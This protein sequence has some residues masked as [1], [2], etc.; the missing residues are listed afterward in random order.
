[1]STG[2]VEP[3]ADDP[4]TRQTDEGWRRRLNA[5]LVGGIVIMLVLIVGSFVI[6]AVSAYDVRTTNPLDASLPPSADHLFGT[7]STGMDIFTRAFYAPRVD[8]TIAAL[9][10]LLALIG[11]VS[12]GLVAGMSRGLVGE[13]AMRIADTLQAFPTLIVAL[14]IVALAGNKVQ[15]IVW[16]IALLGAP[17]FLRLVRSRVLTV[18]EMRYIEAARAMGKPTWKILIRDILPNSI[19]PVIVQFGVLM[20]H[21]ILILAGLAFL[22]VGV[23]A[24]TPEWGTMILAGR[25]DI[26]TGEWWTAVFPGLML[27]VAV[28]GFHLISEGLERARE[29][30]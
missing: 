8:L 9:G 5:P 1:M 22:G 21:G 19:S 23:Q 28:V 3:I 4:I 26:T 30:S 14:A 11:G 27:I 6:P 25:S 16:A 12:I 7:D 10:T 13:L 24:P 18:R 15:N 29:I 20:G 17:V 2:L